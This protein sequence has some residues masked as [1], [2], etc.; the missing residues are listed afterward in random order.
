MFQ[1]ISGTLSVGG[2]RVNID[3]AV[4]TGDHIRFEAALETG[5]H[6]FSGKVVNNAIDGE[7]RAVG[8]PQMWIATRTELREARFTDLNPGVMAR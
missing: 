3:K 4:L 7:L 8:A 1:K 2:R 6:E 5:R